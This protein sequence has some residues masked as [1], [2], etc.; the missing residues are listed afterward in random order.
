V[1]RSTNRPIR[2]CALVLLA[3]AATGCDPVVNLYGSFF[4]A[5]VICLVA[6]TG[7]AVLLRVVFAFAGLERHLGPLTLVYPSLVLLLTLLIWLLLFRG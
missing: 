2:H 1:I 7:V 6:G 3:L 5:W 4:P